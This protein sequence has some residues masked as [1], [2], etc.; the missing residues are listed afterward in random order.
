MTPESSY[1][2]HGLGLPESGPG[3]AASLAPRLV[4]LLIDWFACQ[5]IAYAVLGG[6]WGATGWASLAPLAVFAVENLLLVSTLGTTLGHRML[7]LAVH[8]A[9]PGSSRSRLGRPP[10]LLPTLLRTALLCLVIPPLVIDR[11]NRG[12]HDRAAGTVIVRT[13]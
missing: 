8:S 13:R 5:L 1:P 2:R 11:D 10:G 4:A 12:W 7:G 9:R 6:G 3:S